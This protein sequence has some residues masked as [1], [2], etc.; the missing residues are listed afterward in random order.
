MLQQ[1]PVSHRPQRVAGFSDESLISG[2][3]LRQL[4][5]NCSGMHIWRLLNKQELQPLGFPIPIKIN[6]RNYWRLGEIRQWIRDQ[7]AKSRKQ[8]ALTSP[9]AE[10]RPPTPRKAAGHIASSRK[11]RRVRPVHGNKPQARAGP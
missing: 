1:D 10:T 5:G 9:D 3:Q 4:L 7:E 6:G 2:R 11:S 8:A